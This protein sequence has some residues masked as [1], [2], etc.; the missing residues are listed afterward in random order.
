MDEIRKE[1]YKANIVALRTLNGMF[2]ELS[3]IETN[4]YYKEFLAREAHALIMVIWQLE[5]REYHE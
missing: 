2:E 3:A 4:L 1:I 5:R